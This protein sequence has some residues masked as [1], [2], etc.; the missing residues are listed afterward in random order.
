MAILSHKEGIAIVIWVNKMIGLVVGA[1]AGGFFG[2]ATTAGLVAGSMLS[3][4]PLLVGAFA[5]SQFYDAPRQQKKLQAK[6]IKSQEAMQ[7]KAIAAQSRYA[8]EYL[9]LTKQQMEMQS[10]QRQIDTLADL[11]I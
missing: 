5:G 6:A 3:W 4:T 11:I 7:T 10:E 1:L 2:G 9:T 8:G